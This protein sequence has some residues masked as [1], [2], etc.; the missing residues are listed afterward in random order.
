MNQSS[1]QCGYIGWFNSMNVAESRFEILCHACHFIHPNFDSLN[2]FTSGDL[3]L[4]LFNAC[5]VNVSP[6]SIQLHIS[7]RLPRHFGVNLRCCHV[8]IWQSSKPPHS[9][10]SIG[11]L[12]IILFFSSC[13]IEL[14]SVQWY[15]IWWWS[16][17]MI[18]GALDESFWSQKLGAHT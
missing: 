4:D 17:I 10:T 16:S 14:S 9:P 1:T 5:S 12:C 8:S 6:R 13:D 3:N 18:H 2:N 15:W 11:C 7:S